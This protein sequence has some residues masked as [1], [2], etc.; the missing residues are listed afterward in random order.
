MSTI[1]VIIPCYNRSH[2]VCDAVDSVLSQQLSDEDRSEVIVVDDGSTDESVSILKQRYGSKITVHCHEHNQGVSAARNTGMSLATGEYVCFLDSDD[3][4]LEDSLSKRLSVY[5]ADSEFSG[6]TYGTTPS[7]M[8]RQLKGAFPEGNVLHHYVHHGLVQFSG[9]LFPRET[10]EGIRFAT[11]LT[12]KEDELF[13]LQ[14]LACHE[15][16]FVGDAVVQ[17]RRQDNSARDNMERIVAQ[18]M[19][20]WEQVVDNT[21]LSD[22]LG[23]DRV[24]VHAQ[25]YQAYLRALWYLR[26]YR[27]LRKAYRQAVEIVPQVADA[28]WRRRLWRA[29]LLGWRSRD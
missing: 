15:V 9:F 24:W 5:R 6:L 2:L 10:L 27:A 4:F 1:S 23:E 21:E 22:A 25:A 29:R 13:I 20:F 16:R 12:N 11:T 3:L 19:G 7:D 8:S 18:G 26:R 28:K 17:V 14:L